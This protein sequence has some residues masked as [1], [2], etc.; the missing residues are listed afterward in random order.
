MLIIIKMKT[1]QNFVVKAKAYYARETSRQ[2][3]FFQKKIVI[4]FFLKVFFVVTAD[5]VTK[6]V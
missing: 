4:L 1:I 3:D 2:V 5:C 6:P